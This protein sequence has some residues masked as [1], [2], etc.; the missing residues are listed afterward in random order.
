[1]RPSVFITQPVARSATERLRSFADVDWNPDPT[2]TLTKEELRAAV[3]KHDILFCLLQDRVDGDV[4]AAN[5]SLRAVASM[6]ITPSDIDVAAATARRIPVTVIPPVVTE[7]T[8]DLHVGLLLAVARRVVEGE[9]LLRSGVFPGAQSMRLEGA[10][11][12]GKTI[13]LIGG[14]GRIG[15]AVARRARGFSMRL[16]YWGPRRMAESEEREL[17]L[18]HVPLD[19]LLAESDFV[20]IHAPLKLETTHLI[21][22]RELALMRPSAFLVN[23][24]R[25]PIVDE[26]ALVQALAGRRIAGAALDVFED[27]PRVNPALLA[28]DNVVLTPHLGSAVAELREAM[29]H[30]VVDN[31]VAILQGRRPPNCWNPEIYA[32]S[33]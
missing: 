33:G 13:G 31:I 27:E 30:V 10:F 18:V 4:I 23:T 20:S 17:D 26:Q 32:A 7:A 29:A 14:G 15:R 19:R 5:A 22:A 8:A 24:A 16:L 12:W 21:G 25:G 3:R 28:M 2:H 11:V 9:R 6:K 1:M